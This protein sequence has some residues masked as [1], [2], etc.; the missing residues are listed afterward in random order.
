MIDPRNVE[1]APPSDAEAEAAL[2]G[3]MLLD[4]F[5]VSEV[6]DQVTA[7][8]FY[9]PAHRHVF[10]AIQELDKR[11]AAIDAI[12]VK[13]ELKRRQAY[14]RAGGAET[15]I[16]LQESVPSASGAKYHAK[17]VRD[18][19]RLRALIHASQE[20]LEDCFEYSGD[21]EE[22]IDRAEQRVFAVRKSDL[23]EVQ[24]VRD[25]LRATIVDLEKRAEQDGSLRGL[26]TGFADLNDQL[27][28]LQAG[29]LVII[30]ARPS[31][32]KTTFAMNVASQAA[33]K[34]GKT[35]LI[36]SL[37]VPR[38][39]V[40]EN[41]LCS[42]SRVDAHRMRK[43][44]ISREDWQ[45]LLDG[46]NELSAANILIDD[47]PG[48][49]AAA[50]RA[51]SRRIAAQFDLGV[52]VVDYMQLMQY[53]GAESRQHEITM[54]SQSLKTTARQLSIPVLAL[55]Q[56]NRAVDARDDHVPRMSDLRESGSI[57]QDAD[58]IMF[59]YREAYYNPDL[60][61]D[62]RREAE[63]VIAKHRNGPTGRIK[64]LFMNEYLRFV[65]PARYWQEPP[66]G[67]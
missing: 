13:D 5:V 25:V 3:A 23:G 1:R 7:D 66:Q 55:S 6:G 51:K 48:I 35:A 46:A 22:M 27:N 34:T 43:G 49:S 67:G 26:D 2:L 56:L 36:F 31:M 38:E 21:V 45:R 9:V 8:D 40:V 52:I 12:T 11:G 53:P 30:A 44:Q 59:L 54:I 60:T 24:S 64:L 16:R 58:V 14:E 10:E 20:N 33:M 50:L 37:E 63:V 18:C 39:L 62:R 47:T 19:A 32:G 4:R 15:L 57:E 29:N 42:I 41:L 17:I 61:E 65:D 28:G